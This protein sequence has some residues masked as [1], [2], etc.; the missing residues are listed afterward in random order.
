MCEGWCVR[1]V[2]SETHALGEIGQRRSLHPTRGAARAAST[3]PHATDARGRHRAAACQ[4]SPRTR[5]SANVS[6]LMP[7]FSS[8]RLAASIRP[9]TPSEPGPRS[10]ECGMVEPSARQRFDERNTGLDPSRWWAAKALASESSYPEIRDHQRGNSSQR[11]RRKRGS[12]AATDAAKLLKGRFMSECRSVKDREM[13]LVLS[14]Y[15]RRFQY[16][17]GGRQT[18]VFPS[19]GAAPTAR[20]RC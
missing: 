17:S 10:I 5:R 11:F 6:N 1:G 7:R 4:S 9:I 16:W 20:R 13:V 8:K 12:A 3:S 15:W 19:V 2:A 18:Y 14:K